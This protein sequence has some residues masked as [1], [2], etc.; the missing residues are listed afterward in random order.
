M[1][2]LEELIWYPKEM[3]SKE[4]FNQTFESPAIQGPV[5]SHSLAL[6][7]KWAREQPMHRGVKNEEV[8]FAQ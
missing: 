1:T 4:I 2:Q 5:D 8:F 7:K 6:A 3:E